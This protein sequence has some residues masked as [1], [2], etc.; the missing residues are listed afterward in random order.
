MSKFKLI[1]SDRIEFDVKFT[2]N[3]SGTEKPFGAKF[4]ADRTPM[5]EMQPLLS[6]GINVGDF[7]KGRKVA[8][9][10]WIGKAPL[11]D[12]A[13]AE[14]AA[15]ADALQALHDMVGGFTALLY[16]GYLEANGAKGRSGN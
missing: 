2:L 13:G 6:S 11:V 8:M 16:A 12:E 14:V 9:K 1:V 5:E 10:A 7:L 4:V 15:G 3:D